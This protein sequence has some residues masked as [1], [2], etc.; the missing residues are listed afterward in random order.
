MELFAFKLAE[1]GKTQRRI[2]GTNRSKDIKSFAYLYV[3]KDVFNEDDA[4]DFANE[5]FF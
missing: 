3:G 1:L 2:W 5:K 4:K